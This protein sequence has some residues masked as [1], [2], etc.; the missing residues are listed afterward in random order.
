MFKLFFLSTFF[1]F[2][3]YGI[4]ARANDP[5]APIPVWKMEECIS[6][7]QNIKASKNWKPRL[8]YVLYQKRWKRNEENH[9]FGHARKL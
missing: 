4:Q 9:S 7:H 5:T 8:Y 6:C 2:L 3:L 1:A